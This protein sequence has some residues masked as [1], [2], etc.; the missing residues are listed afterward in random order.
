MKVYDPCKSLK[1]LREVDINHW[2]FI[3]SVAMLSSALIQLNTAEHFKHN[4]EFLSSAD[5]M[6]LNE[7]CILPVST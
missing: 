1:T 6:Y 3:H 7:S 2:L 4:T 5:K